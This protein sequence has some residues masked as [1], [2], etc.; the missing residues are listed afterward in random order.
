MVSSI[1]QKNIEELKKHQPRLAALLEEKKVSLDK[2]NG[3]LGPEVKETPS[4]FWVK[5]L[6]ERP[7]FE[8]KEGQGQKASPKSA[9]VFVMGC[10]RVLDS[11]A[12]ALHASIQR[13]A[14]LPDET[15]IY[16]GHEYTLSN[17]KFCA[18]IE[19]KNAA[20]VARLKAVEALRAADKFTAPTTLGEEKATNV[21]LRAKDAVEFAARREAKNRF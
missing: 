2:G 21:F 8:R 15:T 20:I 4:G 16:V 19:P 12:E 9:C 7:F 5:G 18:H 14:A 10:G 1:W 6:T 17:A 3:L 13:I 11:T